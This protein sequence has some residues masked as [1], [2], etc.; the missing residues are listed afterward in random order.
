[1]NKISKSKIATLTVIVGMM[2]VASSVF[3]NV[4]AA[5]TTVLNGRG[6]GTYTCADGTENTDLGFFIFVNKEKGKANQFKLSGS[7]SIFPQGGFDSGIQGNIYGGKIG[8]TSYSLLSVDQFHSGFVCPNDATPS[9][10][11]VTGQ[12]G[13]GVNIEFKFENGG[14]GTFTGNIVCY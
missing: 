10:G 4:H 8:K 7:W 1:M 11:T 6:T 12:C 3:A 13:Q 9:K 2:M 5:P 14:H